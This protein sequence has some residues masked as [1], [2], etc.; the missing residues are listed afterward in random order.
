MSAKI[1]TFQAMMF[2]I[3]Q[4]YTQGDPEQCWLWTGSVD[5]YGYGRVSVPLP[6][7]GHVVLKAHRVAYQISNPEEDIEHFMIKLTCGNT[8]CV[9]PFHLAKGPEVREFARPAMS[10]TRAR[11]ETHGRAK[12]N[13]EKVR[14][15]RSLRDDDGNLTVSATTLAKELGV[16]RGLIYAV[17]RGAIWTEPGVGAA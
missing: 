15:I 16:S 1:P 12:L 9:N 5:K 8:G 13:W 14:R 3:R 6:M 7:G 4:H 10:S 11:G 2:A 17:A